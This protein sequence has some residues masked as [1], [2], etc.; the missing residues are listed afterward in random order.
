MR[1]NT[2]HAGSLRP[3]LRHLERHLPARPPGPHSGTTA[4]QPAGLRAEP[5]GVG[6]GQ[7]GRPAGNRFVPSRLST[8]PERSSAVS[9]DLQRARTLRP[10]PLCAQLRPHQPPFLGASPEHRLICGRWA[11]PDLTTGR[12]AISRAREVQ[13]DG[14]RG[15]KLS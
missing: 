4:N 3:Y 5:K 15:L 2:V 7:P 6:R 1:P 12:L 14:E 10:E 8:L 11:K 9:Q 13:K